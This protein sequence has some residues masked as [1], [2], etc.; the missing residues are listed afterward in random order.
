MPIPS[1]PAE[2][3]D[4]IIT[5]VPM[6]FPSPLECYPTLLSCCLVCSRWLPA[7]RHQLFREVY[8]K[9]PQHYDLLVARVLRQENM[10]AIYWLFVLLRSHRPAWTQRYIS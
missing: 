10:R 1:L 6:L 2:V 9:S 7:S 3:T 5:W 4:D 8:L